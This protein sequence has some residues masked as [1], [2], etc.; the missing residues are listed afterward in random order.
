MSELRLTRRAA[1]RAFGAAAVAAA[2]EPAGPATT[3]GAT[4]RPVSKLRWLFGFTVQANPSLPVILAKEQGFFAEQGLD[5]AWDFTT[6]SSGIRLIGTGQYQL[7]SVSDVLT[8]A[9]FV[10]EGIPLKAIVQ[11]SQ[12]SARAWAVRANEGIKRPKDFERKRVGIRTSPWT[13]YLAMLAYDKVDRSR[14]TEVPIGFA[15]IELQNKIIDVMP[16]FKGVEPFLFQNT[17]KMPFELIYPEDFGYPPVGTTMMVNANFAK[18]NPDVVLRFVKAFLKGAEFFVKE[19]EQT[20]R[21]TQMYA[22]PGTTK[23]QHEFIW[24]VS[25]KDIADR[26]AKT[27]GVGWLSRERWQEQVDLLSNLGVL[28]TKPKVDDLIDTRFVEQALKDGKLVWP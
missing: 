26:D 5:V 9:N 2:C 8:I 25:A 16:T 18:D 7:G 19:K 15:G 11:Q 10:N 28:K 12:N 24:N 22:G 27:K 23:E 21:L 1:L 6:D 13:E 20:L 4:T 3:P 17:L 14:I